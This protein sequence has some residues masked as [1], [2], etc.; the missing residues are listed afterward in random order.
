VGGDLTEAEQ[1]DW[2]D[3][4]EVE[5]NEEEEEDESTRAA[6]ARQALTSSV[7]FSWHA[8]PFVPK[9][10][11]VIPLHA[12]RYSS[13][14]TYTSTQCVPETLELSYLKPHRYSMPALSPVCP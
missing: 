5:V 7:S 6:A 3:D 10:T 12:E 11:S 14:S 9:I 4:L 8:A 1:D 2:V 13:A